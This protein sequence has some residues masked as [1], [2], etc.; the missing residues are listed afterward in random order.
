MIAWGLWFT[1]YFF[2]PFDETVTLMLLFCILPLPSNRQHLS[3]DACLE[4]KRED[5]QNCSV[6]CCAWQLC[7]TISTHTCEQFL[8]F[9]ML[10]LDLFLSVYLG[11]VFCVFFRV[12]LGHFVLVLLAFVFHTK[13]GD[14]LGRTSP[15]WPILCRGGRK[16]LTQSINELFY[17]QQCWWKCKLFTNIT[18]RKWPIK[19]CHF[20]PARVSC[21]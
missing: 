20:R 4:D 19:I 6:L 7:T 10:G 9:C 16:T 11:F 13:P 8:Q 15:I 18:Y 21:K 17:I 1:I 3:S 12:S 2:Q 14:W 5:N